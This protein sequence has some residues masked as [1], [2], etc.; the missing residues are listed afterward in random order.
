M[1][2]NESGGSSFG[3]G[4]L[5]GLHGVRREVLKAMLSNPLTLDIL[6]DPGLGLRIK[7]D[8]HHLPL[9]GTPN[10]IVAV[11]KRNLPRLTNFSPPTMLS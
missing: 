11:V 8:T 4:E 10:G 7:V 1:P 5:Q 9:I 6:N 3:V 2:P